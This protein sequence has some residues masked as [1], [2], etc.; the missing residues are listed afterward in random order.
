M[1]EW[2]G[3]AHGGLR[4]FSWEYAR[5]FARSLAR[6]SAVQC[7]GEQVEMACCGSKPKPSGQSGGKASG[8]GRKSG[9]SVPLRRLDSQAQF[10]MD[11]H[12]WAW[13]RIAQLCVP[14][15][16][17][18]TGELATCRILGDPG[19]LIRVLVALPPLLICL[20]HDRLQSQS[21]LRT[22]A[23]SRRSSGC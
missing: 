3:S 8:A 5:S 20:P 23:Q 9:G 21:S 1:G 11:E 4:I 10:V 15:V 7:S 12:D 22:A 13:T 17:R 14:A 6:S 19:A 2:D 18:S 16:A